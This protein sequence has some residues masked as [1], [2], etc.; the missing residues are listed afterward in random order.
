[1]ISLTIVTISTDR[2]T[3]IRGLRRRD[4]RRRI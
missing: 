4:R 2:D 3:G 1:M